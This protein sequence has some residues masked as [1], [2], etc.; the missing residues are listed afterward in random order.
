[1]R[2]NTILAAALCAAG[3]A[4][5]LSALAA[6]AQAFSS[7]A[8]AKAVVTAAAAH[9]IV[10]FSIYLPLRHQD[11]LEARIAQMH[12]QSSAQY[13]QW[14]QPADFLA[15]YGPR[16]ADIKAVA[17]AL[18][19]R[20]LTIV[21]TNGHG[22]RA[23]GTAAQVAQAL[24]TPIQKVTRGTHVRFQASK[25]PQVPSELGTIEMRVVG[26]S[27]VPDRKVH[28]RQVPA[29]TSAN[30]GTDNRYG[31]FGAYWYNDL[32]QAYDYPAY[33]SATDGSNVTVAVL[34]SDQVFPDDI[35]QMFLHEGF[36]ATTGKVAPNVTDPVLINGGGAVGGDG[37]F[38]ASLDVQQ[39]LG[40][41][42]GSTVTL[43]SLPDL[44]DDN[45]TAGYTA[46]VDSNKY[47]I[48]N[49]SFGGCE[50]NYTKEYNNGTDFTYL[51]QQ[52]HELFLQGNAQGI[53]FV[54]SSGD[55]AGLEC[56]DLNYNNGTGPGV[57]VASVSTPAADP[58]V[59]AVGGGNLVTT[60]SSTSLASAYVRES[61]F[62]EPE[63]LGNPDPW[64]IGGTVT[65]GRWGAGGG[66][67]VVFKKPLYQAL[68]KTGS[69]KWRTIPDVGMQVGGCPGTVNYP[70]D[71]SPDDSAAVVAYGVGIGG[72][73]S[74]V[75]GTSVSSPE[76]VGALAVFE[77][78][79]GKKNH[80][81][82][83]VNY[84]LYTLAALQTVTGGVHAPQE[85]QFFHRNNP[86][87]NGVV[88][89][90]FPS[91]NYNYT[92]GNGSPDVRKLFGMTAYKAA[93]VPRT[94][95]NP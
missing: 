25:A 91:Y 32:K 22:V 92:Y 57:Y 39:V 34:M 84:Y 68:A 19:A 31:P 13:H 73:F 24:A 49:S 11:D 79:L 2:I 30:A 44:G 47:D 50:L 82:G 46:I 12:D 69:N 1:M 75:I 27:T 21:S 89:D 85:F 77:Q 28:S 23:S 45:I 43:V 10:Q 90:D 29:P 35:H 71:C 38:E 4:T 18:A 81:V 37:T 26:L 3:A 74:G 6:P 54:A 36:S 8:Q 40:G 87:Y 95:T 17:T 52:Q 94:A 5:S 20:G 9:D 15:Q 76:F 7:S 65:G 62:S 80:R 70:A 55:E 60:T 59:T 86:G 42:P 53:T 64:N 51:L 63:T 66:V 41:A 93:G 58:A 61:E 72:G 33:S 56:P 78:Q 88:Y 16:P 83:N 48:V 67:S 14:M